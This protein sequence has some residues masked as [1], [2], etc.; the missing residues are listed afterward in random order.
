MRR[1]I[2]RSK[3]KAAERLLD[4]YEVSANL[5]ILAG[6]YITGEGF[7]SIQNVVEFLARSVDMRPQAPLIVT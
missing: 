7:G 4:T 5:P 3:D 1:P 2:E 6:D